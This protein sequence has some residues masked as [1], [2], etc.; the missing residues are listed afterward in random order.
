MNQLD[1]SFSDLIS[2][3]VTSYDAAARSIQLTTSDGRAYEAVLTANTYAKQTQNLGEGWMDRGGQL[4]QLLV[5]GQMVFLYGTFFPESQVSFEVNYLVCAGD[6]TADHRYLEQGWWVNQ[7][8]SIATSYIKWQ[9]NAPEEAIDYHNYRTLI[10]LTGGKKDTDYLQETDTISRMVYGMAS[11][12]MLTGKDEF[13]EA[14]EKG[15]DYLRDK[16]RFVDTDTGLI[17]WYHGQ[18]VSAGGQEQKLLVSEFGDDYDCI[19]AYEQIYALAGPVQT[20]RI[21]GDPRILD[22]AEK[23][24]DLFDQYFRDHEKG[25]Y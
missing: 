20:Y 2:G 5:P 6:T 23:T 3:Y 21:S 9:F 7:I 15:T 8:D 19:P 1:F 11:A 10:S 25:G 4:E 14:A 16:M 13:L 24:I 17:Y 18:K 12:Y 22:D